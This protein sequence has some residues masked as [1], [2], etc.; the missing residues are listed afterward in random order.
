MADTCILHMLHTNDLHSHFASMPRIATCL[1]T[2][3]TEWEQRDERVLTL[4][5]GD[6]LDRMSIIT[7]ASLGKVNVEIMSRSGYQYATIG[8]NEGITLT[9]SKLDELYEAAAF[10]VIAG[11]LLD[12]LDEAVP[13]WAV[14][15]A[16]HQWS[17]LR[18]A[19]L[20]MTIPYPHSYKSMGWEIREVL[21][22]LVEQVAALRSQAD[23][24]VLMSHLG[25]QEDCRL[26]EQVEGLDVILGAHT[27]HLLE[28]GVRVGKT[29]IAQTGRFGQYVGHVRLVWDRTAGQITE[30]TAEVMASEKYQQAEDIVTVICEEQKKAEK[31][32][33]RPLTVLG[34]DLLMNWEQETPFASF[35]AA[36]IREKT[37][38][39]IGLANGGLLLADLNHG[40]VTSAD[41]LRCVPHPLNLCAVTLTGEQLGQI[42][43]QAIQ[44]EIVRKRLYGC[45]FRGQIE[46]WMGVDGLHIQYLPG[47]QP[48]IVSIEVN[49][50]PLVNSQEYRVGTVDM[51]MYNRLFPTLLQGRDIRFFLPA[52]L[53]E[54]LAETLRNEQML[55]G[56]FSPRWIPV[57]AG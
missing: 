46:G 32:L 9:K 49:G 1:R 2:H 6:H 53:R 19:L 28:H 51:F 31:L 13:K 26:A 12:G 48:S 37:G 21:P 25:Y 14:P 35:L 5:I 24:I 20:A 22:L 45:G 41:L 29:L 15:Y 55:L 38:A 40:S 52:M 56:A 10:T 3:R 44:P 30:A 57:K 54:I 27:H 43:E 47:E 33:S 11:N 4:D 7:E 8:N 17:D 34:T 18:V 42:L 36:S 16:I 39:E 23:I 50:Q